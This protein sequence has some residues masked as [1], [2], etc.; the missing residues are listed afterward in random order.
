MWCFQ[1]ALK[2]TIPLYGKPFLWKIN[3]LCKSGVKK[4]GMSWVSEKTHTLILPDEANLQAIKDLLFAGVRH[5]NVLFHAGSKKKCCGNVP[6]KITL[7]LSV[8]H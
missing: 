4:W 5:W 7:P 2:E 1:P 8:E 3:G 6:Q